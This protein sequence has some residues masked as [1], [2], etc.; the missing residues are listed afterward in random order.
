MI[1]FH[2]IGFSSI[3]YDSTQ[4]H[5][6]LSYSILYG[7]IPSNMILHHSMV[8]FH[9]ICLHCFPFH[10]DLSRHFNDVSNFQSFPFYDPI[11]FHKFVLDSTWFYSIPYGSITFHFISFHKMI[12]IISIQSHPIHYDSISFYLI[13]FHPIWFYSILWSYSILYDCNGFHMILSH[14]LWFYPIPNGSNNCFKKLKSMFIVEKS[15]W[16]VACLIIWNTVYVY[17]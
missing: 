12:H 1:L 15:Y 17:F 9:S 11:P 2:S 14:P 10:M 4:N 5:M 8:L 13:P 16:F 6:I 7:S 3:Q